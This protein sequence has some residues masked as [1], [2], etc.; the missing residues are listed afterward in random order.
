M[1]PAAPPAVPPAEP[2][3]VPPAEPPAVPPAEPPAVPPAEPPAV[4]PAEP[5]AV[6]PAAPPAEP[7]AVPPAAPPAEPPPAAVH[8]ASTHVVSRPQWRSAI[9]TAISAT[10][11]K[12]VIR[13][14]DPVRSIAVQDKLPSPA[15]R[16]VC[17]RCVEME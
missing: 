8:V 1:P 16:R 2:P 15:P 14:G 11:R 5:P 12:E 17:V 3:A 9:E 13:E 6:P 4:P 7:P 10:S